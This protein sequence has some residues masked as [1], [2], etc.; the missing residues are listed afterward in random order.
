MGPENRG[1]AATG[2]GC[3]GVSGRLSERESRLNIK[4]P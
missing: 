1:G 3:L 4:T 2:A